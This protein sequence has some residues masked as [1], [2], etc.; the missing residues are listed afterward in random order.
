[1]TA[2][3]A[4]DDADN[5]SHSSADNSDHSVHSLSSDGE[6]YFFC[7]IHTNTDL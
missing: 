5:S 2:N 1:M 3:S 6:I 7:F 4:A